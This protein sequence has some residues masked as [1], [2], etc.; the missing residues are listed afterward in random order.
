M[1]RGRDSGVRR[2]D[3]SPVG[4][5]E[6]L[7]QFLDL[8]GR[9]WR[10]G[11]SSEM[12]ASGTCRACLSVTWL[13]QTPELHVEQGAVPGSPAAVIHTHSPRVSGQL[14]PPSWMSGGTGGTR[15]ASRPCCWVGWSAPRKGLRADFQGCCPC[16]GRC[17][18][19]NSTPPRVSMLL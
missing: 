8:L 3:L 4:A 7:P 1:V 19:P 12:W 13:L 15:R 16:H 2:P 17:D 18:A 6:A 14:S 11:G 5:T 9:P 10:A